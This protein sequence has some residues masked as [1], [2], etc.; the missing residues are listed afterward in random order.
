MAKPTLRVH[1]GRPAR[2]RG[3]TSPG[4]FVCIVFRVCAPR[5]TALFC[6]HSAT[7]ARRRPHGP[8]RRAIL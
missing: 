8:S 7:A 1:W 3:G 4:G 5:V 2:A 6:N